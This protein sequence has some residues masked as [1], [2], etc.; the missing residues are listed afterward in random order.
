MLEFW[1]EFGTLRDGSA[2]CRSLMPW[3]QKGLSIIDYLWNLLQRR[4]G[5]TNE[6]ILYMFL[7]PTC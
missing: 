7:P 5:Q 1:F 4:S 2:S 3:L 6:P